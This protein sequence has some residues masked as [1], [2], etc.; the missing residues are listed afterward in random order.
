LPQIVAWLVLVVT[1]LQ[2]PFFVS[3]MLPLGASIPVTILFFVLI[4]GIVYHG[5]LTQ[6]IDPMDAHLRLHLRTARPDE[7]ARLSRLFYRRFNPLPPSP[8]P[9]EPMK[10]CWLCEIQVAEPSLHCRYCGKC[11]KNFDHHC[12]CELTNLLLG[13]TTGLPFL[14]LSRLTGFS[15][16]SMNT[17]LQG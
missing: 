13:G 14:S 2:F 15:V 3:P 1:I 4:S 9:E 5:G 16:F 12:M 8:L 10:Q 11:V 6:G 17:N 7:E